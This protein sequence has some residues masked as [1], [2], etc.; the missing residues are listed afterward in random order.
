MDRNGASSDSPAPVLRL[1]VGIRLTA[2]A[3]SPFG[4][5]F[6]KAPTIVP[7]CQGIARVPDRDARLSDL[8][9][10]GNTMRTHL[11]IIMVLFS[12]ACGS[13]MTESSNFASSGSSDLR[14]ASCGSSVSRT[15][16]VIQVRPTGA[17]DTGNLQCAIDAAVASGRS[18]SIRLAAG[19][20]HTAQIVAKNFVGQIAGSGTAATVI[21]T[22]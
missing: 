7:S 21:T 22:L 5:R 2:I 18:T 11:G 15:A 10:G 1:G 9:P 20:F 16:D 3:S 13:G 4:Q 14:V 12:V 17:D 8:R 6:P 19:T